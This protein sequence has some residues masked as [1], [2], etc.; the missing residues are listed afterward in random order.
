RLKHGFDSRRGHQQLRRRAISSSSRIVQAG[1]CV[2]W[3]KGGHFP[4]SPRR[5]AMRIGFGKRAAAIAVMAAGL[6]LSGCMYGDGY[7]GGVEAGGGYGYGYDE[8]F[9]DGYTPAYG[10]YGDYYYPGT[11]FYVFDRGG[12]RHQ[13]N[14]D[15]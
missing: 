2:R 10:W 7:Y 13:W 3:L 9:Y 15:Q 1:P 6:A 11:G 8:P 12:K 14:D 4:C 5:Q